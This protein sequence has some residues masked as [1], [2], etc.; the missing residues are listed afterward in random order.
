MAKYTTK[1]GYS[2]QFSET[3]KEVVFKGKTIPLHNNL[4]VRFYSINKLTKRELESI[5]EGTRN[6]EDYTGDFL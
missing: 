2:L 3:P 6:I 4:D 1:T 5:F